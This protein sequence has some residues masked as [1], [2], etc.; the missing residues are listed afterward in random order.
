MASFIFEIYNTETALPSIVDVTRSGGAYSI[1]IDE[2]YSGTMVKDSVAPFGYSTTDKNLYPH[3][4]PIAHALNSHKSR[5]S[6]SELFNAM[7]GIVQLITFLFFTV[8]AFRLRHVLGK[9]KVFLFLNFL[10]SLLEFIGL[11]QGSVIG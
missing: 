6:I 2:V 9:I 3:L 5:I 1:S 11:G 8:I 7:V 10:P 4:E